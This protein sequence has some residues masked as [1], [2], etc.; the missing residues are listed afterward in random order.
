M[1]FGA[2]CSFPKL[3]RQYHCY[4]LIIIVNNVIWLTAWP[5]VTNTI[6]T[7]CNSEKVPTLIFPTSKYH[8]CNLASFFSAPVFQMRSRSHSVGKTLSPLEDF[9]SNSI[10]LLVFPSISQ[11]TMRKICWTK[12]RVMEFVT[13]RKKITI[14]TFFLTNLGILLVQ[15]I[16]QI[17]RLETRTN[18]LKKQNFCKNLT[19]LLP[20]HFHSWVWLFNLR[21]QFLARK[22]FERE[23]CL[24]MKV[25]LLILMSMSRSA[26]SK[27]RPLDTEDGRGHRFVQQIKR[28]SFS[29]TL[30][31]YAVTELS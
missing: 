5:V 11:C 15:N 4:H 10:Q 17:S 25:T 9:F 20:R 28:A 16:W 14:Y 3:P 30:K 29:K 26:I 31:S 12:H 1:H 24:L 21:G 6:T 13:A 19:L 27:R 22:D 23:S 18:F 7:W 8:K 2:F